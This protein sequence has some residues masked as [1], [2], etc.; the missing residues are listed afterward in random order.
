[1]GWC[2]A[3]RYVS[4]FFKNAIYWKT[5]NLVI[6]VLQ[7]CAGS[8]I[9]TRSCIQKLHW[10]RLTLSHGMGL[11]CRQPFWEQVQQRFYIVLGTVTMTSTWPNFSSIGPFPSIEP[12]GRS[13]KVARGSNLSF[14][15]GNFEGAYT[16]TALQCRTT[17]RILLEAV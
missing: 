13:I 11:L 4:I 14:E 9:S 17:S 1:M 10:T 3:S 8:K 16:W 5:I 6:I 7:Y 2:K 12:Q 15:V